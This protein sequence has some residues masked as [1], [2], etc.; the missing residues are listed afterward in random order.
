MHPPCF[1]GDSLNCIIDSALRQKT[2]KPDILS[3]PKKNTGELPSY[4]IAKDHEGIISEE[5]FKTVQ[6]ELKRRHDSG[7]RAHGDS[8]F[9]GRIVCAECGGYYGRKVWHSGSAYA[10]SR[11]HCNNRFAKKT[12]CKTPTLQEDD[13][14]TAFIRV[15]NK[16]YD[17]RSEIAENQ[18]I[19]LDAIT[20]TSEYKAELEKAEIVCAELQ[21]LMKNALI[22]GAKTADG[23]TATQQ[24]E[25][26]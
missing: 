8:V 9:S 5:M 3:S 10:S 1:Q 14:K 19:C 13:L 12:G 18:R 20:D 16:L 22:T 6:E 17:R 24:Y 23:S 15:F 26:Y 11:W 21:T 4:F 7:S 25:D 2:L